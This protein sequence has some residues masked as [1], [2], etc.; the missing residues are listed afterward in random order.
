MVISASILCDEPH[1]YVTKP[2]GMS[3]S[4]K[5]EMVADQEKL[6]CTSVDALKDQEE[7][8]NTKLYCLCSDGDS[9]RRRAL[10]NIA[11]KCAYILWMFIQ[12]I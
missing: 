11:L 2:Y 3:G 7:D 12:G 8:I 5:R 9:R 10:I 1:K 6:I 4:C